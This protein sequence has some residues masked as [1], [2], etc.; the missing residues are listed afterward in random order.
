MGDVPPAVASLLLQLAG[1]VDTN[2][3]P[4]CDACGQNFRQSDTPLT[5]HTPDCEIRTHQLTRCSGVP[6]SQHCLPWHCPTH[7]GPGPPVTTQTSH[8]CYSCHHPFRPGTRPL[9]CL[10]QGC[11]NLAHAARRC[12]GQP[13]AEIPRSRTGQAVY[14]RPAHPEHL[15]KGGCQ[16]P[17]AHLPHLEGVGVERGPADESL[18]S[19]AVRL[20][21]LRGS[22]VATFGRPFPHRAAGALPKQSPEGGNR[23]TQ[24]HP[25]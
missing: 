19:S 23:T 22:G 13:A 1:D 10:A 21:Y 11:M 17:S 3:C 20:P 14:L 9:V 16:M 7:G 4:S 12:G 2:P 8:A 18:Q 25:R 15:D 24:I 6:R 5:C